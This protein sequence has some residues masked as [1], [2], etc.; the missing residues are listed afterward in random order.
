MVH[1]MLGGVSVSFCMHACLGGCRSSCPVCSPVR[2]LLQSALG[3]AQLSWLLNDLARVNRAV[4][5]WIIVT[6][7]Q[8][9]VSA[10]ALN[11]HPCAAVHSC[12]VGRADA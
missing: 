10:P 4:T 11:A 3:A 8:P 9:V 7:H 12:K 1:N 6:W 2:L 5:P